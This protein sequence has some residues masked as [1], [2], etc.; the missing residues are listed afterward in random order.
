MVTFTGKGGEPS[1]TGREHEESPGELVMLFLDLVL[2]WMVS[3]Y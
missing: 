3:G 2:V 1:M